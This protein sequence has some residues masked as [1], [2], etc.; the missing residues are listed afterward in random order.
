MKTKHVLILVLALV[1]VSFFAGRISTLKPRNSSYDQI[2]ELTDVMT[3]Y[4]REINGREQTIY[5]KNQI[6]ASQKEAIEAGILEK[7]HLKALG[8]KKATQITVLEGELSAARDS[9]DLSGDSIIFVTLPDSASGETKNY[10]ELPFSWKHED[11]YL[12]LS[13]G[14]RKD[15][16]AWFDLSAELPITVTLGGKD[17]KQVAA[18]NTPSPYVILTDFN[19]IRL[20][21]E[22][23]FY[24]PWVPTTGG[25]IGGIGLGW[26][27]WG[28]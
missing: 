17:G 15:Q 4:Q 24:K 16:K 22:N 13:T 3:V 14:I 5:E 25:I 18:V 1:V 12:T 11:E 28:R 21:E 23:W 26:L 9:I 6:L 10:V 8:M 20:K 27:I 2:T 7:D 19:V